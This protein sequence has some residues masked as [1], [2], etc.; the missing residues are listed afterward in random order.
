MPQRQLDLMMNAQPGQPASTRKGCDTSG[1]WRDYGYNSDFTLTCPPASASGG[2]VTYGDMHS[3]ATVPGGDSPRLSVCLDMERGRISFGKA[4][5]P[6]GKATLFLHTVAFHHVRSG[7]CGGPASRVLYPAVGFSKDRVQGTLSVTLKRAKFVSLPGPSDDDPG[8]DLHR[9]IGASLLLTRW[10]RSASTHTPCGVKLPIRFL[11]HEAYPLFLSSVADEAGKGSWRVPTMA[12][13]QV[14]YVHRSE[15]ACTY[16]LRASGCSL[17]LLERLHKEK[18]LVR[19][20]DRID[21]DRGAATII[22]AAR[23]RLWIITDGHADMGAW[24]LSGLDFENGLSKEKAR[25]SDDVPY[26]LS[27]L[28]RE[29]A[30]KEDDLAEHSVMKTPPVTET[31]AFRDNETSSSS[32]SSSSLSSSS[33]PPPSFSEFLSLALSHFFTPAR[34]MAIVTLA[35]EQCQAK[36]V[37]PMNLRIQLA[38]ASAARLGQGSSVNKENDEND[39]HDDEND[40]DEQMSGRPPSWAVSGSP[41]AITIKQLR[42][43]FSV[44][45]ALNK[46]MAHLL[47]LVDMSIWGTRGL[48]TTDPSAIRSSSHL[49]GILSRLRRLVF[50]NE[51]GL[52]LGRVLSHTSSHTQLSH[53]QEGEGGRG[54]GGPSNDGFPRQIPQVLLNY[55]RSQPVELLRKTAGGRSERLSASFFGQLRSKLEGRFRDEDFRRSYLHPEGM[56]EQRDIQ[57]RAFRVKFTKTEQDAKGAFVLRPDGTYKEEALILSDSGGP[58]RETLN[59]ATDSAD[60]EALELLVEKE[61]DPQGT[62]KCFFPPNVGSNYNN[63]KNNKI[64]SARTSGL[65]SSMMMTRSSSAR[66]GGR[67]GGREGREIINTR[68]SNVCDPSVIGEYRFLGQIA[69][70]SVRQR[71]ALHINFAPA[72]WRSLAGLHLR[73]QDVAD[74]H[75]RTAIDA[76]ELCPAPPSSSSADEASSL[77]ATLR[78]RALIAVQRLGNSAPKQALKTASSLTFNDRLAFS[79]HLRSIAA[80]PGFSGAFFEAFASG[81]S[82]SLPTEL[83]FLFTP[84]ELEEAFCGSMRIETAQLKAGVSFE[85]QASATTREVQ[86]LWNA[87]EE[88]EQSDRKAFVRF[89]SQRE[90]LPLPPLFHAWRIEGKVADPPPSPKT[91]SSTASSSVIAAAAA[92][93]TTTDIASSGNAVSSTTTAQGSSA[94][95]TTTTSSSSSGSSLTSVVRPRRRLHLPRGDTCFDRLHLDIGEHAYETEDEFKNALLLAIR[96][97]GFAEN[98]M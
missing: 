69:G 86:W 63:N 44:L 72:I 37:D 29:E 22:G 65:A 68:D 18:R 30:V 60:L 9:A 31:A 50:S 52:L 79:N 3:L 53:I 80:K 67:Q 98:K 13:G 92:S 39:G 77:L 74:L 28:N 8:K 89:V 47:P 34:D 57:A 83:L 23:A 76:I 2:D 55:S 40:Y 84:H 94:T 97:G 43:R 48:I 38:R 1:E 26:Y 24:P 12:S 25:A 64:I 19:G 4:T 17:P 87:L 27:L 33:Q 61:S 73:P 90:S 82:V 56:G 85:G 45:Q 51:K 95:T 21:T 11:R 49:G 36:S 93:T 75:T 81:L 78:Q 16:A 10:D 91:S 62:V 5:Y 46:R 96:D 59:R 42:A 14:L 88:M 66:Q 41:R 20:G 15:A 6:F 54:G 35:N 70:M 71:V 7:L 32:L 58:Y